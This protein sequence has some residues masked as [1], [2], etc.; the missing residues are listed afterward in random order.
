MSTSRDSLIG[1]PPSIVSTTASSRARSWMMRE[2]RK[3]YRARR[4]GARRDQPSN[5]LSAAL[6]A[7]STSTSSASTTSDSFCSVAGLMVGKRFLLC[8]ATILPPMNSPYRGSILTWSIDSGAGAY[9]KVCFANSAGACFAIA[10]SVDREVVAGLVGARALFLDLHQHVV[11]QRGRAEPEPF[12]SHPL[13]PERL[14]QHDQ[15]GDGLLG[16]ADTAGGLEADWPPSL[17]YEVADRLHHHK[18]HGQGRGR[19]HL[20]GGR[21]D[22]V[23]ARRHGE[24]ARP[25]HVVVGPELAGLK[26]HLQVRGPARLFDCDDLLVH[27]L[28]VAGEERTAVDHHVHFV[29]ARRDRFLDLGDLHRGE[30][31]P[32]WK[33]C[34]YR[35]DAHR[36]AAQVQFGVCDAGGVDTDG[37]HRGDAW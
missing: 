16:C 8:G 10:M 37:G 4:D 19:L 2:S 11:E 3:M 31:L 28:V 24:D 23:G 29:G 15:I 12:G 22:E 30:A 13:G 6:T 21:L 17:P 26:D 25:A 20:A 35:G 7:W 18:A 14:V 34:G 5:A 9:S 36:A 33:C 32:R 27:L 1:L